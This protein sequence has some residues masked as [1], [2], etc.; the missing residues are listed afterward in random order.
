MGYIRN[1]LWFFLTSCSIYSRIATYT[2]VYIH[3][4]WAF[5]TEGLRGARQD[6]LIKLPGLKVH[7]GASKKRGP[8]IDSKI[9]GL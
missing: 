5:E 8:D 4:C 1:V 6:R 2:Y 9:V 3:V 7:M